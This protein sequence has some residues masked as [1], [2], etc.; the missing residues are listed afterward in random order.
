MSL[1]EAET[2][3]YRIA[4]FAPADRIALLHLERRIFGRDAYL[5]SDFLSILRR[6]P[7]LFFVAKAGHDLIGYICGYMT[8]PDVGYIASLG[9]DVQARRRG[10]GSALVDTLRMRFRAKGAQTMT[11]HVRTTNKAAQALYAKFGFAIERRIPHY[12]PFGPDD[13]AAYF[14]RAALF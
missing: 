3:A 2:L 1:P 9:V 12:F 6:G 14:M 5:W 4:P 13:G 10:L 8:A 11:L 7:D